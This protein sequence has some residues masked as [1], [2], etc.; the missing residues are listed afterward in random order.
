MDAASSPFCQLDVALRDGSDPLPCKVTL[1][2]DAMGLTLRF[3]D[4]DTWARTVADHELLFRFNVRGL[5]Y[6]LH[7]SHRS[8]PDTLVKRWSGATAE[9]CVHDTLKATYDDSVDAFYLYIVPRTE[10][11]LQRITSAHGG[12]IDDLKT[13]LP[14]DAVLDKMQATEKVLGLEVLN[15]AEAAVKC[16]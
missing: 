3:G 10:W 12:Y 16:K 6:E 4:T 14:C 7:I 5:L 11:P 1:Q 13:Q 9:N 2:F 15:L 8:L